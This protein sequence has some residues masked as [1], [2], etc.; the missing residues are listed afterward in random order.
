M[1]SRT[2]ASIT[3]R[4]G[5]HR[6]DYR[7]RIQ[8]YQ[9]LES[10]HP[11][12]RTG[13]LFPV[14][15]SRCFFFAVIE[16]SSPFHLLATLLSDY[17]PRND[18][19]LSTLVHF[20]QY[21]KDRGETPVHEPDDPIRNPYTH[22]HGQDGL[23]VWAIMAQFPERLKAFQLG[24]MSQEDSVPIIGFY[25]FSTLHDAAGDG[26][27]VTLVDVGGGQGQSI[28]QIL[29]A[30]PSLPANRMVLQDL[31]E[32]IQQV[33]TAKSLPAGVVAMVHD[34]WTPQPV[35]GA[36]AYFFR[37]IMHDYSDENCVKIL[38]HIRD[39]MLPDSRVLIADMVM[40]KRVHEA[41]LPAAAMDNCV[42][43]MGGKERTEQGFARIL[44]DAGLSLHQVWR[45][46]AG[47]AA[48]NIVEARLKA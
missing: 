46:R 13:E 8:A 36:K 43:V 10:L 2:N 14:H 37:R 31:P 6:S 32:P 15:A 34:F 33:Q 35:Q 45:S 44:D 7:R 25:D 21:V 26:E 41:D 3:G 40:P 1:T 39:A 29:T 16:T 18:E 12:A 9:V 22:R 24:F 38:A 48:G 27:R 23:P 30:F 28:A 17:V 5:L 19:C 47:G 20:H 4:Y 42:M 11:S